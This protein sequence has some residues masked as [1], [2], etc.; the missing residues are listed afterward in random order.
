MYE[1]LAEEYNKILAGEPVPKGW[2]PGRVAFIPKA[3]NKQLEN[4]RP[5][6]VTSVVYRIFPSILRDRLQDDIETRE[7]VGPWQS[8]FRSGGR[9]ED[10]LFVLTE[11][12]GWARKNQRKLIASF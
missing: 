5:I 2:L 7:L 8:G 9:L 4:R 3:N 10:S 12:I 1:F 6:T 11:A